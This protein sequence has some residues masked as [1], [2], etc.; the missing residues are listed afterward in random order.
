MTVIDIHV[1][2]DLSSPVWRGVICVRGYFWR[3]ITTY[4]PPPPGLGLKPEDFNLKW[5]LFQEY[6]N[7]SWTINRRVFSNTLSH[8]QHLLLL[9]QWETRESKNRSLTYRT[10]VR[11][12][13]PLFQLVL[14][15]SLLIFCT[16]WRVI[17]SLGRRPP[18]YTKSFTGQWN[19]LQRS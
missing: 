1:I 2:G 5:E 10:L 12:E 3:G 7:R 11:V 19:Q 13:K 16:K 6:L 8:V 14:V 15:R 9:T 4:K 17:C 18:R